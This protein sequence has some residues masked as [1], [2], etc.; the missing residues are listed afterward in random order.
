MGGEVAI[1]AYFVSMA[2]SEADL[3]LREPR[4]C[5]ENGSASSLENSP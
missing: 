5:S 4:R 3:I 1:D 2:K